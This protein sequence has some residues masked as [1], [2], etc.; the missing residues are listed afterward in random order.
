MTVREIRDAVLN[1]ARRGD[2][3]EAIFQQRR[4]GRDEVEM[5]QLEAGV[6]TNSHTLL[7]E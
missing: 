6:P 7:L 5:R 1:L 2:E 4:V 3:L